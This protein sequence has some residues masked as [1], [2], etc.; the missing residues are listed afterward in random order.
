MCEAGGCL[1]QPRHP[2]TLLT[3]CGLTLCLIA[4]A[5][6]SRE[7][8]TDWA[9]QVMGSLLAAMQ[10]L[11]DDMLEAQHGQQEAEAKVEASRQFATKVVS[12]SHQDDVQLQDRL[13]EALR[14]N[15][16]LQA[17]IERFKGTVMPLLA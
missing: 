15:R 3:S 8:C 12:D 10:Q 14:S 1:E 13:T 4:A 9:W 7:A 2:H 6:T 16:H 5:D 17:E 11:E